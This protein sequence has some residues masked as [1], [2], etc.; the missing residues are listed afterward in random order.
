MIPSEARNDPIKGN[1]LAFPFC[2]IKVAVKEQ[3]L[4]PV[5]MFDL[6]KPTETNPPLGNFKLVYK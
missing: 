6:S 3:L 4:V 1:A 2:I 5:L